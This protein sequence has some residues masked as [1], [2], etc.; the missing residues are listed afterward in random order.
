SCASVGS[1]EAVDAACARLFLAFG[2]RFAPASGGVSSRAAAASRAV[3]GRRIE[4]LTL[5]EVADEFEDRGRAAVRRHEVGAVAATGAG[6][7]QLTRVCHADLRRVRARLLQR[8]LQ[9]L[10]DDDA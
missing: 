2:F 7:E 8:V 10:R 1:L 5:T 9:R 4:R 6:G 3:S